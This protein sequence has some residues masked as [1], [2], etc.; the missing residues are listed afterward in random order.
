GERRD[1][2]H[3]QSNDRDGR[4]DLECPAPRSG[5]RDR[6]QPH[7]GRRGGN[8]ERQIGSDVRSVHTPAGPDDDDARGGHQSALRSHPSLGPQGELSSF[9]PPP[10]RVPA[11]PAAASSPSRALDAV[12]SAHA[13]P[14]I[15]AP[16]TR[17]PDSKRTPAPAGSS[18]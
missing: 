2:R 1:R 11:A 7:E 18:T 3:Q 4:D 17:R 12:A 6:W 16:G 5:N 14:E 8:S 13:T 15:G 9:G 10:P